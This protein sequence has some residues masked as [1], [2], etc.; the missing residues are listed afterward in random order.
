MNRYEAAPDDQKNPREKEGALRK[1]GTL[2]QL[3]GNSRMRPMLSTRKVG[4]KAGNQ[5]IHKSDVKGQE[6]A[7]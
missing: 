5:G 1:L 4:P 7:T 2:T 6:F 3:V